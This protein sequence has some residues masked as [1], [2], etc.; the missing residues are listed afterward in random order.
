MFFFF[1]LEDF[2]SAPLPVNDAGLISNVVPMYSA[3]K[4]GVWSEFW[5]M[6]GVWS[7]QGWK[8]NIVSGPVFDALLPYGIADSMEN[9]T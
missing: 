5:R 8:L 3:F 9:L 7:A 6:V 2:S 1:P 4:V